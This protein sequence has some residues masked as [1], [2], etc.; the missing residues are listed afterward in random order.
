MFIGLL[1]SLS[2]GGSHDVACSGSRGIWGWPGLR[3]GWCTRGKGLIF[4]FQ[5]FS[6]SIDKAFI[7]AGGTGRWVV[8]YSMGYGHFPHIS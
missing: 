7:L 5:E 2:G 3:V 6:A 4:V 1:S 8:I